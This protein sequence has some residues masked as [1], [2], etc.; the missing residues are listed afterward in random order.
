MKNLRK[1]SLID[2][3]K[4]FPVLSEEAQRAIVAGHNVTIELFRSGYGTESTLSTFNLSV[5]GTCGQTESYYPSVSGY[6]L[7]PQV[8]SD[9]ATTAGSDTAIPAGT[10]TVY[11]RPD[12]KWEL[13]GVEGRSYIQIHPGNTGD[14]TTGCFLPGYGASVDSDGNYSVSE[15]NSMYETMSQIM[16]QYGDMITIII[17]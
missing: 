7:E 2:L 16:E 10:Y 15:S 14:D 5:T 1:I 6:M 17:H 4:N 9:L 12:G 3:E 13:S 11:K 8:N